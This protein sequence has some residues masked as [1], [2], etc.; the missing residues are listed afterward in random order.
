MYRAGDCSVQIVFDY[1]NA[2]SFRSGREILVSSIRYWEKHPPTS[3]RKI[4]DK[5]RAEIV[6]KALKYFQKREIKAR[7]RPDTGLRKRSRYSS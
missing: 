7:T 3:P 1:F 6:D 5:T 4:D 2:G